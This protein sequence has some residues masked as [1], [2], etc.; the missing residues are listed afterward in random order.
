MRVM[1]GR[2]YNLVRSPLISKK[3][4]NNNSIN[5]QT[6]SLLQKHQNKSYNRHPKHSD[7]TNNKNTNV[8]MRRRSSD[9]P[10]PKSVQFDESSDKY[11]CLCGCFHVKT[12]AFCIAGLLFYVKNIIN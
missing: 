11:R 3:I 5:N 7:Q 12:G 10:L 2:F 1:N 8:I 9:L 6:S 4:F